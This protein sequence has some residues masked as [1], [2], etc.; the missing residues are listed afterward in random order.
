MSISHY[1]KKKQK[2]QKKKLIEVKLL[3]AL[4]HMENHGEKC[5]CNFTI[6]KVALEKE[7][8]F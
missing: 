3:L 1:N 4:N 5:C 6:H 8:I 7:K 2:N